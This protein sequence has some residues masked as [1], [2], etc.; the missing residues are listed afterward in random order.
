M[1]LSN[2]FLHQIYWSDLSTITF[3]FHSSHFSFL[4][5]GHFWRQSHENKKKLPN[6]FL[7]FARQDGPDGK[8][9]KVPKNKGCKYKMNETEMPNSLI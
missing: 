4:A 8:S 9:H 2:N 3:L 7:H 1:S 6:L 5:F